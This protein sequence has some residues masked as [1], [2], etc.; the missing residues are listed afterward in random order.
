LS[1]LRPLPLRWVLKMRGKIIVHYA[2][3]DRLE[4]GGFNPVCGK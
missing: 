3:A 4:A 2:K 1:F